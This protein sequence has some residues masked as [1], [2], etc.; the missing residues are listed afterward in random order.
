MIEVIT[1]LLLMFGLGADKTPMEEVDYHADEK[2]VTLVDNNKHKLNENND[3]EFSTLNE[4]ER[5]RNR[6]PET[7]GGSTLDLRTKGHNYFNP[8]KVGEV[9]KTAIDM[10]D[11]NGFIETTQVD[12][13]LLELNVDNSKE[14]ED[15]SQW[16][17]GK[18]LVAMSENEKDLAFPISIESTVPIRQFQ[19]DE[20]I[21]YLDN[22]HSMNESSLVEFAMK[23][24]QVKTATF[25]LKVP[26]G[27][28][29]GKLL[30][31]D[32]GLSQIWY[33]FN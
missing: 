7:F 32:L 21:S 12:V 31:L 9:I 29:S 20:R 4:D 25:S 13:K 22:G 18:I 27:E 15:G 10:K 28:L 33:E 14:K 8:A 23:N 26:E 3:S 19:K 5:L 24:D 1:S 11:M 16:V 6:L 2:T 30:H 17:T